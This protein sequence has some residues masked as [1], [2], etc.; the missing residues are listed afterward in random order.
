MSIIVIIILALTLSMDAFSLSLIY[1]TLKLNRSIELKMSIVVGIFH[2]I[3]PVIGYFIGELIYKI[4][5]ISP[6]IIVGII[7]ILLSIEM[8]KSTSK[9]EKINVLTNLISIIIFSITVSI[10]S[11]SIGISFGVTQTN[12]Y[13]SSIIFSLCSS[14]FTFIGLKLGKVLSERFGNISVITGSIILF[15]LGVKNLFI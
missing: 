10:D 6:N 11:L 15:L 9:E 12:I 3:M 14:L 7:F 8:L 1:G 4:I 5:P 2:F 13:L